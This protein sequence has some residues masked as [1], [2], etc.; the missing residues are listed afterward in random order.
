MSLLLCHCLMLHTV[1]PGYP[2]TETTDGRSLF[3]FP[4]T[5]QAQERYYRYFYKIN[6]RENSRNVSQHLSL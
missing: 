6:S 4:F 2:V 1:I 3:L 5:F